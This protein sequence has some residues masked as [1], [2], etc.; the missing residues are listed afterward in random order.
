MIL[1]MEYLMLQRPQYQFLFHNSTRTFDVYP[2][3]TK[4]WARFRSGA[5]QLGREDFH[6]L[7]ALVQ[8]GRADEAQTFLEP[9]GLYAVLGQN[10]GG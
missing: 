10:D 9:R 1:R 2:A 7:T 3:P 4:W 8:D 6:E 5:P